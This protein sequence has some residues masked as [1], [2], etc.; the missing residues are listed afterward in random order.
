LGTKPASIYDLNGRKRGELLPGAND[1]KRFPAGIYFVRLVSGG[2][3]TAKV[4]IAR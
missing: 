4:V 2:P 1:L 3:R